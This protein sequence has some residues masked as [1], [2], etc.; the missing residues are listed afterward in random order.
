MDYKNLDR[1]GDAPIPWSRVV[2]ELTNVSATQSYWLAT[3]RPDGHPHVAA[4]GALWIDERFYFTSGAATRKSRNLAENASCTLSVSLPT[5]DL[6]VEGTV[7]Q[8]TD[9][10]TL[11][12]IAERYAA[13]GWPASASDGAI[14]AAYS[15]PSAG[16]PP[17]NLYAI[18]PRVAFGVATAEP[19]GA[20]RWQFAR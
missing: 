14:T 7:S 12:R 13:R 3:V 19:Y 20:M 16:P 10:A 4:V 11:Q 5:I 8:I 15:A 18:T 6:V 17:W 9:Q 2:D 1:Y